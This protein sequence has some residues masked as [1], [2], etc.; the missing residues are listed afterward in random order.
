MNQTVTKADNRTSYVSLSA[1]K[2]SYSKVR[3]ELNGTGNRLAT[4]KEALMNFELMTG[5]RSTSYLVDS[6]EMPERA[7]KWCISRETFSYEPIPEARSR[8]FELVFG[9]PESKMNWYDKIEVLESA[10]KAKEKGEPVSLYRDGSKLQLRGCDP[11]SP[12]ADAVICNI[13]A[14]NISMLNRDMKSLLLR[15]SF[16]GNAGSIEI[17]GERY[18]CAGANGYAD[19]DTGE[20]IIFANIQNISDRSI[21]D[22]KTSFSLRVAIDSN[23]KFFK[24]VD[25]V[26]ISDK[27]LSPKGMITLNNCIDNWNQQNDLKL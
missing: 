10:V 6:R 20:I 1:E 19:P 17:N 8:L 9:S 13:T 18:S 27:R 23:G 15:E 11:G 16:G 26:E 22:N 21:I 4:C 12:S 24:I 2:V 7:G 14:K 5:N 3:A 25:F